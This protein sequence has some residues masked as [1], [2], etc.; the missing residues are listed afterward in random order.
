MQAVEIT[1]AAILLTLVA[2]TLGAYFSDKIMALFDRLRYLAFDLLRDTGPVDVIEP[3]RDYD[4]D[5]DYE[6]TE[7]AIPISR[8]DPRLPIKLYSP[9]FGLDGNT[10]L[11]RALSSPD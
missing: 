11:Y 4:E 6:H 2:L 7:V 8:F 3:E 10:D 5:G 1:G 9:T